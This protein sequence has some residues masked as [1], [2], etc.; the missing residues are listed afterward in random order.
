MSDRQYDALNRLQ[1]LQYPDGDAQVTYVY[2]QAGQVTGVAD[3]GA[4]VNGVIT[5]MALSE[6]Q[7]SNDRLAWYEK[8]LGV[9]KAYAQ[10]TSAPTITT[11]PLSS[12]VTAPA[13]AA[14]TVVATGTPTPTY[15]WQR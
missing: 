14:F 11:Q 3:A 7:T 6:K 2:N 12:T 4:V 8:L 9:D 15:Q 1:Q 5:P 10:A 13:T